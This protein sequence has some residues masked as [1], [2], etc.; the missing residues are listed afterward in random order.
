MNNHDETHVMFKK[1]KDNQREKCFVV[2]L[3]LKKTTP[4]PNKAYLKIS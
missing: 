4:M 1:T 3:G 2:P